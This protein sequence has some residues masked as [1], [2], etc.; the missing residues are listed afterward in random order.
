MSGSTHYIGAPFGVTEDSELGREES[1][2][3]LL[4]YL[5]ATSHTRSDAQR[6]GLSPSPRG[7]AEV[8][9]NN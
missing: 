1:T 3:E 7:R 8:I 4:S 9:T 6:D 5:E 2:E